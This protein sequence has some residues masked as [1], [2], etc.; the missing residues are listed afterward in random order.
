[1]N[2]TDK[3]ARIFA[4]NVRA[5][6]CFAEM[7]A[8]KAANQEREHRGEAPAYGEDVFHAV[9]H[10]LRAFARELSEM[11]GDYTHDEVVVLECGLTE[12]I[13][14][15]PHVKA[16]HDG[17]EYEIKVKCDCGC[18]ETVAFTRPDCAGECG[19]YMRPV[20][21]HTYEEVANLPPRGTDA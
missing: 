12:N 17:Q 2:D 21:V 5:A 18:V 19:L 16:V 4:A 20:S 8:F 11:H 1:M 9:A 15:L 10:N 13:A 3:L 14:S 7:E 6:G